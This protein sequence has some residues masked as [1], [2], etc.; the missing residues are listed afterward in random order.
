[1]RCASCGCAIETEDDI[2]WLRGT[3]VC[4]ECAKKG[5][6]FQR[7]FFTVWIVVAI[8]VIAVPIL[9]CLGGYFLVR[10]LH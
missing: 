6:V 7:A 4:P 9:M 2:I 10:F 1:M 5:R 8:F 3:A